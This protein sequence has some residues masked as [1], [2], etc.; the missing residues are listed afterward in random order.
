MSAPAAPLSNARVAVVIVLLMV[1]TSCG[2]TS[3]KASTPAV[4]VT[5]TVTATPTAAFAPSASPDLTES[6]GPAAV[7]DSS[8]E[9]AGSGQSPGSEPTSSAPL[10]LG[11]SDANTTLVLNNFFNPDSSWSQNQFDVAS[12]KAVQGI[13][14]S[15]SGCD[16]SE[17][18]EL[19]LRLGDN[20]TTLNFEVGLA[21][22]SPNSDAVLTVAV[23]REGVQNVVKTV[24]DNKIQSFTVGVTGVNSLKLEFFLD[25]ST[26]QE[27]A[28]T[29][30]V[31]APTLS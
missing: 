8:T 31:L 30:V 2:G 1:L 19:E 20:F 3:K 26:C 16:L 11:S 15:I 22:D 29:A 5:T 10:V 9:D 13:G 17:A 21:N 14:A 4:T 27:G 23:F 18:T 7:T 12:R 24:P 25:P 6:T 28:A